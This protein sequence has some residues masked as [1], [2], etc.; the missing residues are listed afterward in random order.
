VAGAER[1]D[2]VPFLAVQ[3]GRRGEAERGGAVD[4][5]DQVH[6]AEAPPAQQL[7]RYEG[8]G[9]TPGVP[10]EQ[11]PGQHRDHLAAQEDRAVGGHVPAAQVGDAEHS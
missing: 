5:V 11:P 1:R 6:H 2:A 4:Q 9:V 8:R 7:V 3:R 10:D